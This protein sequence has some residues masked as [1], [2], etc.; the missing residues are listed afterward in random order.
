[1]DSVSL[2]IAILPDKKVQENAIVLSSKI[3]QQFQTEFVLNTTN[4]LPHITVYQAHFPSKN[5][6]KIK[7]LLVKETN[8][9]KPIKINLDIFSISYETFLFWNCVRTRELIE[10]Q[11][12]TI[13]KLNDLREGLILPHIKNVQGISLEDQQDID[14]YGSLLIGPRYKPHITITRLQNTVDGREALQVLKSESANDSFTTNSL[15]L[16]YLG[17]HGTVNGMI[18]AFNL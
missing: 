11:K 2:N 7:N 12:F 4:L 8:L 3:A 14:Q 9:L 5:I 6:E 13:E 15:V 16:A 1:M 10:Y 18:D 17:N